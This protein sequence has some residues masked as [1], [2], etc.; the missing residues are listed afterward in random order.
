[1]KTSNKLLEIL[2]FEAFS[3]ANALLAIWA[4]SAVDQR[5]KKSWQPIWSVCMLKKTL[6]SIFAGLTLYVKHTS[7][8]NSTD[9]VI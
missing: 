6:G 4:V 8:N 9:W 5:K 1:M 7:I 3:L 2:D